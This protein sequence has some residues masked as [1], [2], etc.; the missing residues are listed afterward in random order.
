MKTDIDFTTENL[1]INCPGLVLA[2][3]VYDLHFDLI[4]AVVHELL[5]SIVPAC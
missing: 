3:I 5:Y 4:Q 2:A 1:L